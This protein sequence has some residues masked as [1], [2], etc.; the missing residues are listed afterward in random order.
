MAEISEPTGL[1]V[2]MKNQRVFFATKAI[3]SQSE[4]KD[5]E[6]P[7]NAVM[8]CQLARILTVDLTVL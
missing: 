1:E 7:L 6:T 2:L 3:L 8:P 5:A 4:H